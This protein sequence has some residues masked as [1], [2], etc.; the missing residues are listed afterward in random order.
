MA[1]E[2]TVTNAFVKRPFQQPAEVVGN[3]NRNIIRQ[4]E[5]QSLPIDM[6]SDW[7]IRAGIRAYSILPVGETFLAVGVVTKGEDDQ[8]GR[9]N[10]V[11]HVLVSDSPSIRVSPVAAFR[12][13]DK[14]VSKRRLPSEQEI[15]ETVAELPRAYDTETWS[16]T[17][18]SL[19]ADYTESFLSMSLP[20]I[21]GSKTTYI[22][23]SKLQKLL[24]FMDFIYTSIGLGFGRNN[25]FESLCAS[26]LKTKSTARLRGIEAAGSEFNIAKE[27]QSLIRSQKACVID[28]LNKEVVPKTKRRAVYDLLVREILGPSWFGIPQSSQIRI[29]QNVVRGEITSFSEMAGI[30][31]NLDKVL[32]DIERVEK[33]MKSFKK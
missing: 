12:W 8:F 5:D 2:K 26:G 7:Y 19:L 14:L 3:A 6:P 9:P 32:A 17:K 16:T 23:Y 1:G 24:D 22:I 4:L 15:N 11:S 20:T 31:P 25:S 18:K 28:L 30:E 21:A 33:L 10:L 29:I 27:A 13:L